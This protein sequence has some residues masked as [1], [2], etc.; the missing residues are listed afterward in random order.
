MLLIRW[1]KPSLAAGFLLVGADGVAPGQ[2]P[3]SPLTGPGPVAPS[4]A[5]ACSTPG[6][7]LLPAPLPMSKPL[8]RGSLLH[9]REYPTVPFGYSVAMHFQTHVTNGVAARMALYDY[10]FVPG[11][12]RLNFRG[13]DR[14]RQI[15]GL[16]PHNQFPVIVARLPANPGL[17]ERRR[18]VVLAELTALA[19]QVPAARVVVSGPTVAPLHG[20]EAELIYNNLL[21]LTD[22]A[23]TGGS[24]GTTNSSGGTGTGT[25]GVVAPSPGR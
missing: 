18:A 3:A 6:G 5:A 10:D 13:N 23:G 1:W 4:T 24:S 12:D 21:R 22:S 2:P 11:T 14:V 7:V 16:I 9:P 17:A 19:G 15:A 8:T 20:V 25:T